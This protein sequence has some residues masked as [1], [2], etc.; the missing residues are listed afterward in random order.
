M[1]QVESVTP[2]YDITWYVK[3][4]ASFVLLIGISVRSG[5]VHSVMSLH[6]TDLVCSWLGALGWLFVGYKWN[7][8]AMIL[9]NGVIVAMTMT[10]LLRLL[11][12]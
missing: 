11:L 12:S 7:D 9:I 5:N 8:R 4:A 3:W 10:S 6:V 1:S 2:K